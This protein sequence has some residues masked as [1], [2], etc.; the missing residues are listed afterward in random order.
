LVKLKTDRIAGR[1][2]WALLVE[3]EIVSGEA[4]VQRLILGG[5]PRDNE[6]QGDEADH[7]QAG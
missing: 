7:D 1:E 5:L 6:S 2:L 3:L 4:D